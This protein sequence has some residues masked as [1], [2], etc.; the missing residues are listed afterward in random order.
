MGGLV[1]MLSCHLIMIMI[2]YSVVLMSI[3]GVNPIMEKI[4]TASPY[5]YGKIRIWGT[6]GYALGS[7]LAGFYTN[8]FHHNLFLLFLFSPCFYVFLVC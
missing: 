8:V 7:Q 2:S 3:N 5:Q 4:A 6:I 1:F